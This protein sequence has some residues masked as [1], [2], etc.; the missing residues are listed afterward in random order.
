MSYFFFLY[1]SPSLA[2]STV[3]DSILSN[4]DEVLLIKLSA[5]VLVFR[6]FN[7]HDKDWLACSSGTDRSGELCYNFSFS[8]DLTDMVNFPTC[9]HHSPL[10]WEILIMLLSQFLL[11]F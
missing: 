6:D 9:I 3:F 10:H 5:N 4:V 7:V 2:L 11:T 8:N 1:R